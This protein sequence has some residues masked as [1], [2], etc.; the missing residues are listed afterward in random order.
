MARPSC[1][2]RPLSEIKSPEGRASFHPPQRPPHHRRHQGLIQAP[3]PRLPGVDPHP[4]PPPTP[5]FTSAIVMKVLTERVNCLN[6][7]FNLLISC[8]SEVHWHLEAG[9]GELGLRGFSRLEPL[10]MIK[11]SRNTSI[12]GGSSAQ[13]QTFMQNRSQDLHV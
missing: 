1:V 11:C 8:F 10:L 4:P 5:R 12:L 7:L 9:D 6:G 2:S 3:H 13:G